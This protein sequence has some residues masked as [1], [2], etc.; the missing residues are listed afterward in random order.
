[1]GALVGKSFAQTFT[2]SRGIAGDYR[3]ASGAL[4]TA[5]VN[6]PRFDHS[7]EGMRRGL[8]IASGPGR[9]TH[10]SLR[11]VAGDWEA[12]GPATLMI[13]WE[14]ETGIARRALYTRNIRAAVN[15]CT[16]MAGHLRKITAVAGYLPNLGSAETPGYV[17]YRNASYL[18]GGALGGSPGFVIGSNGRPLIESS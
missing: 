1:M 3:S 18:L 15:A 12:R 7:L 2:F 16:N 10:D 8:I 14:S 6:A 4:L 9:G 5:P 17:R 11:V 13:E